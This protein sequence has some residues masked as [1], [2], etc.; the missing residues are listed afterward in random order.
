MKKIILVGFARA[1]RPWRLRVC[2]GGVETLLRRVRREAA[3]CAE[4]KWNLT[5]P[6]QSKSRS[7]EGEAVRRAEMA[8]A[9]PSAWL[10]LSPAAVCGSRKGGLRRVAIR[11]RAAAL[12]TDATGGGVRSRKPPFAGLAGR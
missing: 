6:A 3:A 8:G 9:K 5:A 2:A 12:G 10:F 4:T 11:H 1:N 7:E